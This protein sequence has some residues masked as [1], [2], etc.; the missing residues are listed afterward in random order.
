M[1]SLALYVGVGACWLPV[2]W[3]QLALR[4]LA[5]GA[6]RD[7]MALPEGYHRLYR[8]WFRLGWPAFVGV[9][10]IMW[11]MIAKPRLW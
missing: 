11:L 8:L 10:A 1:L 5:Q 9:V 3:L 2:V 6:A 4:D 7:G